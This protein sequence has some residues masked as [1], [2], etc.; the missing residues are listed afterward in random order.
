MKISAHSRI[1]PALY[2][3]RLAHRY[4]FAT[5]H[6]ATCS[7]EVLSPQDLPSTAS[8]VVGMQNEREN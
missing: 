7:A 1:C 4:V 5:S 6:Y 8:P 2:G 3:V